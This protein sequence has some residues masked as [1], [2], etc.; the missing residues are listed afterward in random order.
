[1]ISRMSAL[2][3]LYFLAA[4]PVVAERAT[5]SADSAAADDS[6]DSGDST[7]EE[8]TWYLDADG[9]SFGLAS[10]AFD[11]C[12]PPSGYVA[13]GTDC[14]DSRNDVYP[15]APETCDGADQD[16]DTV[17]DNNATDAP[18]WFADSDTDGAGSAAN[19][20]QASCSQPAGY[21]A[22]DDDCN[23]A[24][25]SVY[26]GA[27]E[28]CDGV[29]E[30]CDTEIDNDVVDGSPWFEDVDGD[31]YGNGDVRVEACEA[32]E[33]YA[34]NDQDCEDFDAE[35]RPGHDE[36]CDGV[37][38]DCDGNIDETPVDP[39]IWY[40]DVDDDNY[41]TD[42][43]TYSGCEPIAGYVA[44]NTDC[45]DADAGVFPGALDACDGVD[46]D[47][48]GEIDE[49]D[50]FDAL[51]WY[52]DSDGDGY[53][54]TGTTVACDAPADYY[55]TPLDCD[56]VNSSISPGGIETC[57]GIDENCDGEIDDNSAIDAPT[58]YIDADADGFGDEGGGAPACTMPAGWFADATDCDPTDATAYPGADET[59]GDADDHDCNGLI[60][61]SCM[62]EG[63]I[64]DAAASV[65]I[66][67]GGP[68]AVIGYHPNSVATDDLDGDG[69]G[70]LVVGTGS[71]H[72]RGVSTGGAVYLLHGPLV[73]GI[74]ESV[75]D[76]E[77]YGNTEGDTLGEEVAVVGD[78]NG[79]GTTDVAATWQY[80]LS[81][82]F[83]S[84]THTGATAVTSA[85]GVDA[86]RATDTAW[87]GTSYRGIEGVGDWDGDGQDDYAVMT[88]FGV[89]LYLGPVGS[90]TVNVASDLTF[91]ITFETYLAQRTAHGD[92]DH[93]GYPDM[94]MGDYNGAHAY[95]LRGN[96]SGAWVSPTGPCPDRIA[97]NNGGGGEHM[98]VANLGDT[99]G[100]GTDDIGVTASLVG[101]S[102]IMSGNIS[103]VASTSTDAM[104]TVN[105]GGNLEGGWALSGMDMD[106]DGLS[107]LLTGAPFDDANA[108]DGGAAYLYAGPL[109]GTLT[110]ADAQA[111]FSGAWPGGYFGESA[112]IVPDMTG[113]GCPD[114]VVGAGYA[115][116]NGTASGSLYLFPCE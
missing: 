74:I 93:D 112:L 71:V 75:A 79:D 91:S 87:N 23:D 52:F 69:F 48:D 86:I 24:D 44:D 21:V 60:D 101:T 103:G 27:T 2:F 66:D 40:L 85:L 20:T 59:C 42:T 15:N 8:Q 95:I 36:Q 65:R 108:T 14:D 34:D 72:T 37:D 98:D 17:P 111:S 16:C 49:N 26:P 81:V 53:A 80:P 10:S 12:E 89:R 45:D 47:C 51:T 88:N 105:G 102:W 116:N 13:D 106:G 70:D 57:N 62:P 31:G 96:S 99:D 64:Y 113:E 33:G 100:D 22:T 92:F 84:S 28:Y 114:V 4:C 109:S 1:M 43:L 54:G 46:A 68:G 19:G 58:W 32:P 77:V 55:A 78:I 6:G 41:G 67:G 97:V 5:D 110:D 7:C 38:E 90:G 3:P 82:L 83:V 61:D 25:A 104:A 29:D 94:V 56:D 107:E 35:I 39:P 50:S 73:S 11:S 30:D 18:I 76:G 115:G 9:D 63:Q